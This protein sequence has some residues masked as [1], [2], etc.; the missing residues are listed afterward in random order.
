MSDIALQIERLA[1]GEL[2][3]VNNVVFDTIEYIDGNISYDSN[4][5]VITINE[6]GRYV[7]NWCVVTQSSPTTNVAVFTLHSSQGDVLKSNSPIIPGEVIGF[8]IV[9][10]TSVPV[11]ISLVNNSAALINYSDNVP[12]KAT[13]TVVQDDISS[14]G[15][16]GPA[17]P[18]GPQGVQ[19]PAG[20]QG[21]QGPAGSQGSMGDTSYC[22][23]VSQ[24]SYT[25]SQLI[26]FYPDST[27]TVYVSSLYS[28]TGVPDHLY[29]S[30]DSSDAGFLILFDGAQYESIPLLA[31]TAI[32]VGDG[33]VYNN[34]IS[35]LTPPSPLP[36]GCDTDLI[37]AVYSYLPILTD[38]S[39]LL[40]PSVQASGLV[41]KNEYGLLVLADVDGNTPIFIAPSKIQVITTDTSLRYNIKSIT[42]TKVSIKDPKG[43]KI[44]KIN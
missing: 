19:G 9:N 11:T 35:Y 33:T 1:G 5:G 32:Y 37:A 38:V 13:L 10:T 20:S 21:I 16:Q 15:P 36:S 8:G 24:L 14:I 17:G 4:T 41:Y 7:F 26:N 6:Q 2:P 44:P 22:F 28:A 25:L 29:T 12:V 40:G 27:W 3:D 43:K 34:S 31:I 18:I 23:S 42:K 39:I 30:P